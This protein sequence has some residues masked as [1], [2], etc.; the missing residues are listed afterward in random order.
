MAGSTITRDSPARRAIMTNSSGEPAKGWHVRAQLSL[1]TVAFS[2]R[3]SCTCCR[4]RNTSTRTFGPP[5]AVVV[6]RR[7]R[8][9]GNE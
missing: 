7:S 6:W 2:R 5:S 1:L 3:S 9:R 8:V 4:T